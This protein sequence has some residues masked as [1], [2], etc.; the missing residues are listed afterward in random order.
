M[1]TMFKAKHPGW[2]RITV[3]A[4]AVNEQGEWEGE[5]DAVRQAA[6][7]GDADGDIRNVLDLIGV[8]VY[9]AYLD[10]RHDNARPLLDSGLL[11]PESCMIKLDSE[12]KPCLHQKT[13]PSWNEKHCRADHDKQPVCYDTNIREEQIRTAGAQSLMN[14]IVD[15]WRMGSYVVL[16]TPEAFTG[17]AKSWLQ[18]GTSA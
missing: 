13:C 17:E 10:L 11:S 12:V 3:F 2:G 4:I 6:E 1:T 16:W 8:I 7:A 9:H 5:W 18:G 14:R 15:L